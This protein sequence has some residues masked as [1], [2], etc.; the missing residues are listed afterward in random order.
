MPG[1]SNRIVKHTDAKSK[2]KN[3]EKQELDKVEL[4][5]KRKQTQSIQDD[6]SVSKAVKALY[7][8]SDAAKNQPTAHWVTHNPCFY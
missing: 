8:S 5:Q 7:T 3:G 6:P 4:G 2:T 1:P